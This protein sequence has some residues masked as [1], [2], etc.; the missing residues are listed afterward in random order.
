V[1]EIE[2]LAGAL[3]DG[4]EPWWRCTHPTQPMGAALTVG[5]CRACETE[6][7]EVGAALAAYVVESGVIVERA[8]GPG[9]RPFPMIGWG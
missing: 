5:E 8:G 7:A 2:R 6:R 3:A 4:L 1:T 9:L